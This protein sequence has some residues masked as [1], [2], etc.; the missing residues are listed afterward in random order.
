MDILSSMIYL[1]DRRSITEL[2]ASL[3][4]SQNVKSAVRTKMVLIQAFVYKAWDH[5]ADKA[6]A[7]ATNK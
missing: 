4:L 3:V 2:P 6:T 5:T 7:T 1:R